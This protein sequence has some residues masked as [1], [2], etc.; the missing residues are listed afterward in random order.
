MAYGPGLRSRKPRRR[1]FPYIFPLTGEVP[2]NLYGFL[3][4]ERVDASR[5]LM[6]RGA[7]D[8]TTVP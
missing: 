4:S 7:L 3:M 2:V 8:A 5:I 6:L 1:V